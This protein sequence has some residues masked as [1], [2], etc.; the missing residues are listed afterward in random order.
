M[1]LISK[2]L[3]YI[4]SSDT[5]LPSSLGEDVYIHSLDENESDFPSYSENFTPSIQLKKDLGYLEKEI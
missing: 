5:E 4:Y 3:V 1:E 2:D